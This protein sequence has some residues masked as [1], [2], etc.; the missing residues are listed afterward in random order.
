MICSI[1][2]LGA[3][4]RERE[5]VAERTL[6]AEKRGGERVE[7]DGESETARV[8]HAVLLEHG[9]ELGR[10]LNR[11]VSGRHDGL[12]RRL[13]V[14]AQTTRLDRRLGGIAQHREDGALDRLR[15]AWNATS[16]DFSNAS[17]IVSVVKASAW[18]DPR[19]VRAG[20][21]R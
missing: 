19:T 9:K 18:A 1:S 17:A 15:T 10:A 3:A 5:L 12:E 20:S 14:K 6:L 7:E 11:V 21:E 4:A 13:G 2:T 16:T 8:D